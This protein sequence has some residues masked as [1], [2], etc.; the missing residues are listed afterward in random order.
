MPE[1]IEELTQKL[2]EDDGYQGSVYR[3]AP[4]E[5]LRIYEN[6]AYNIITE[7]PHEYE[8]SWQHLKNILGVKVC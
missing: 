6:R 1:T 7:E 3:K 8:P 2:Y 4:V 5:L